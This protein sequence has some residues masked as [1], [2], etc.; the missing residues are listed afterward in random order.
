MIDT[1]DV[2]KWISEDG[3]EAIIVVSEE[4][5]LVQLEDKSGRVIGRT[6]EEARLMLS[7]LGIQNR[8]ANL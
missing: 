5:W 3:K 7:E 8:F 4:Y 6:L 2:T 1:F